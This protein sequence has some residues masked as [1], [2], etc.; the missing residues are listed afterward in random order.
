V[1]DLYM[2]DDR[3]GE[4]NDILERTLGKF[5]TPAA[6]VVQQILDEGIWPVSELQRTHLSNWIAAQYFR[7][8]K[9]RR[10]ENQEFRAQ[11]EAMEA[12]GI[13]AIRRWSDDPSASDAQLTAAWTRAKLRFPVGK[14][15]D[16]SAHSSWFQAH[17]R[18]GGPNVYRRYWTLLRYEEPALFTA[19]NMVIPLKHGPENQAPL[20]FGADALVV[21]LSRNVQLVLGSPI[22]GLRTRDDR[23]A[24]PTRQTARFTNALT[25]DN[26][27]QFVFEHPDDDFARKTP[28]LR[29]WSREH[30]KNYFLQEWPSA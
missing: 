22:S 16:R 13:D 12:G 3:Y 2:I 27:D 7:T 20:L 15:V 28:R 5:E 1:R 18:E 17:L 29:G 8:P 23:E 6:L 11:L 24:A 26:A 9:W 19:D 25:L 14:D 21:T 4:E 10:Y 30:V